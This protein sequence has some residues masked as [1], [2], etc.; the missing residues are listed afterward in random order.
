MVN[1][2]DATP[3]GTWYWHVHHEILCEP[4]TGRLENRLRYIRTEKAKIE[5][6]EQIALRLRLIS[7]VVGALPAPFV[8]ARAAYRKAQAAYRKAQAAS[9]KVWAAYINAWAASDKAWAAYD[10]ARAASDTAWAASEPELEALHAIEHPD[11][12]WDGKSIFS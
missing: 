3:I 10:T 2:S 4:L 6:P 8:K 7:P 12:P 5:T 9:V 1:D 11:C